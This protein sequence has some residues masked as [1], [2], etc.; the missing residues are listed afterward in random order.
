M[1]EESREVGQQGHHW[2]NHACRDL[3]DGLP[4][5]GYCLE[6]EAGRESH[7]LI[8]GVEAAAWSLLLSG[9]TVTLLCVSSQGHPALPP[10]HMWPG[11][12]CFTSAYWTG[13][14]LDNMVYWKSPRFLYFSNNITLPHVDDPFLGFVSDTNLPQAEIRSYQSILT[15][16]RPSMF[17]KPFLEE[18]DMTRVRQELLLHF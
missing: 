7:K 3:G 16:S 11:S 15:S 1:K 12:L 5:H 6:M 14:T 2:C 10:L 13:V 9:C 18:M 8:D 17:S 4:G